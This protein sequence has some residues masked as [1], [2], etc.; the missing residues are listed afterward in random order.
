MGDV[1]GT[2]KPSEIRVC[3]CKHEAQDKIHGQQHRVHNPTAKGVKCTVCGN[4]KPY[5]N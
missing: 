2:N 3:T 5:R 4:I 1:K